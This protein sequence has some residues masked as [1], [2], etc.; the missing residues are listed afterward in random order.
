MTCSHGLVRVAGDECY[1]LPGQGLYREHSVDKLIVVNRQPNMAWRVE[2][3]FKLTLAFGV[4]VLMAAEKRCPGNSR[5]KT[6]RL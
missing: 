6:A 3:Y 1:V 4:G 2:Q 5:S